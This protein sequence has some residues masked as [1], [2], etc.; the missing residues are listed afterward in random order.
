MELTSYKNEQK[1]D[2]NVK[3]LR[4]GDEVLHIMPTAQSMKEELE[5]SILQK[6]KISVL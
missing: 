1:I 5:S 3:Q 6:L 4:F 2:L